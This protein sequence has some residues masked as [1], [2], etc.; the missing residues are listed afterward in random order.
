MIEL[1]SNYNL[2]ITSFTFKDTFSISDSYNYFELSILEH[3]CIFTKI[4]GVFYFCEF[5]YKDK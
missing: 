5:L 2:T 1:F 4:T 3:I